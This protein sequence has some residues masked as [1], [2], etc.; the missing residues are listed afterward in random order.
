VDGGHDPNYFVGGAVIDLPKSLCAGSGRWSV[1]EGDEYD[2]AF[3]AKLPKFHFY[4]PN[5]LIV[6]S[7]EFDH[8][9]IYASL[10]AIDTE[11]T[12]LVT[13]MSRDDT[14]LACIDDPHLASLVLKWRGGQ[15]PR[16]V[17]YGVHPDAELRL[18]S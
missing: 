14:V 15:G 13:G 16:I 4:K 8:A 12:K 1:V 18:Q 9:D 3:F 6:T 11:F 7:V 17:S 5:T 10:D 2:S